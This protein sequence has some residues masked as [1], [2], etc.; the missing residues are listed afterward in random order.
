MSLDIDDEN[1]FKLVLLGQSSVGKTCI[2]NYFILGQFDQ[3]ATPTLGATYA[4]SQIDVNGKPI[5]LQ[6]WDTAGQERYKVLAPMYYRGSHAAILV[7]SISDPQSFYSEID[8][9]VNSLKEKTDGNVQ[10]FLVGNKIDLRDNPDDSEV[11]QITEEEGQEKANSLGATFMETSAA[12]GIGIEELFNTVAKKCLENASKKNHEVKS[13]GDVDVENTN[14]EKKS[15][16]C[17]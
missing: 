11:A 2:V 10:L 3:S 9:W 15:S 12:K 7:Y 5:S 6:I 16:N 14:A 13:K 17:C 4:S 1:E 8:Y